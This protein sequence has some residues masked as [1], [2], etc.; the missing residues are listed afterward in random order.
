MQGTAVFVL[1]SRKTTSVE[2]LPD[3]VSRTVSS[4]AGGST[5][6]RNWVIKVAE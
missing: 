3:A 1:K 2:V 6:R 4:G 5:C